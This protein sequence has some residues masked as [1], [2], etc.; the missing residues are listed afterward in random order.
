MTEKGK[1]QKPVERDPRQMHFV[2]GITIA[3]AFDAFPHCNIVYVDLRLDENASFRLG[4][5]YQD[6]P[7]GEIYDGVVVFR[8]VRSVEWEEYP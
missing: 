2:D 1:F 5:D 8:K 7:A 3:D 4:N 6:V